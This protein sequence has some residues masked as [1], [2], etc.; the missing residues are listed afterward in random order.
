MSDSI[1]HRSHGR[2]SESHSL[3]RFYLYVPFIQ[4][5]QEEEE[6]AKKAKGTDDRL[7]ETMDGTVIGHSN[8][9]I[10]PGYY[11]TMMTPGAMQRWRRAINGHKLET[12][13]SMTS[14]CIV[15]YALSRAPAS[16]RHQSTAMRC[17]NRFSPLRAQGSLHSVI[18]RVHQKS[19]HTNGSLRHRLL[20]AYCRRQVYL[21]TK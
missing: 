3:H 14:V 19:Q 16:R 18:N 9:F 1:E 21:V 5:H 2:K 11:T 20:F 6:N 13:M 8:G 10:M 12:M 15:E 7:P 4:R 17:E